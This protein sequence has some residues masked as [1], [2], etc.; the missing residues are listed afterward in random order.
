M[1]LPAL[2]GKS[3]PVPAYRLVSLR[4]DTGPSRRLDAPMVGRE[5]EVRRLREAFDEVVR[6]RACRR[7]TI[8]GAR[9]VGKTR[10]T[11]EL[12]ES[13]HGAALYG[14]YLSYTPSCAATRV[15]TP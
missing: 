14:R 12:L 3:R 13:N 9:G 5:I 8:V 4:P 6:T 10:L 1:P 2:K 11:R 7:F 15:M